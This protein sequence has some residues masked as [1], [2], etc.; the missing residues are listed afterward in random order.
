M[1]QGECQPDPARLCHV[2]QHSRLAHAAVDHQELDQHLPDA[3]APRCRAHGPALC[4]D[5][6]L[7]GA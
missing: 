7:W 4:R 1:L 3:A 2:L 5:L 6:T